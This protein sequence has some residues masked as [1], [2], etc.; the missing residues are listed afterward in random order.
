M[1]WP[2]EPY[3]CA[4][5]RRS[6]SASCS[7]CQGRSRPA[8][9][10]ITV[11]YTHLDVYK[12]QGQ[13]FPLPHAAPVEHFK[14]VVGEGLVHHSLRKLDVYKRQSY[15]WVQFRRISRDTVLT[16]LPISRAISR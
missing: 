10:L 1:P 9:S 3:L 15:M 12:R 6:S 8:R 11:S 16:F 4:P 2:V 7:L 13:Q 5:S 14:S